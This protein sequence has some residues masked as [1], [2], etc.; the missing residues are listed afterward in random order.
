MKIIVSAGGTG[1]HIYPALAIINKFQEKEKNLEVLYIGTHNRME[2]EIIPK[3]GIRYEE[4]EIYGFSKKD[5][6]LDIKNVFCISKAKKKC[7]NIMKEFKP[8]LVLGVGGYV[9]YPVIWAANKLGIKTFIHEQN[10]IPGKSNLMLQSKAD[11]IGVSFKDSA[12]KFTNAKGKVFYSGNP[13]GESALQATPMP[14]EK[15]GLSKDK[16]LVVVVAGSL[17][18]STVNA[19]MSEFLS[20]AEN[21]NYEVLYITGKSLYEDFIKDKTFPSNVKV[22]PYVDGLPSLL[23][24]TDLI[25]TRAGAS[26]MS[27]IL[28]LNLPAIFIPSPYVA[29]NHQYHNAM[30]IKNNGGGEVIEEKDLTSDGLVSIINEVLNNSTKYNEMKENLKK[31]SM[32]NSSDLIYDKLKEMI[33]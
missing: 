10:S 15:L 2:K 32:N 6:M 23:K 1:G 25:V 28:S 9:T 11:L 14:K 20:K 24:N 19:K 27:E 30:E 21:F 4:I 16:K 17:G 18:S 3:R 29:N 13:C 5:I 8:D 12:S 22:V 31:L 33:K 26:T 7:L